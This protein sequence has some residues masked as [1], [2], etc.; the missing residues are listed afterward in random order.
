MGAGRSNKAVAVVG[1][2]IV[3]GALATLAQM[4]LWVAIGEDAWTLLLRDARLTAALVLGEAVLSPS[5]AFDAG[6]CWS[7]RGSTLRFR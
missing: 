1:A 3:A 5:A 4:L 2:G 7:P 6:S